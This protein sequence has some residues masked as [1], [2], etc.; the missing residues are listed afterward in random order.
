M[1]CVAFEGE[2][3][4]A[5]LLDGKVARLARLEDLP[6]FARN[7]FSIG[8]RCKKSAGGGILCGCPLFHSRIVGVFEPA[9]IIG[10]FDA[11][12]SVDYRFPWGRRRRA[13]RG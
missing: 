3:L 2:D 6:K 8:K 9:I 1:L 10:N 13:L 12:V 7:D 4:T 11:V 5:A